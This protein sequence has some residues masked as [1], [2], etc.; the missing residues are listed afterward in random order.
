MRV[1]RKEGTNNPDLWVQV[2]TYLVNNA[3]S[4]DAHQ[5]SKVGDGD[6]SSPGE[7]PAAVSRGGDD[8]D[9]TSEDGEG[10]GEGAWDDIREVLALIE[11]EKVLPPLRV[12]GAMPRL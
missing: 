4:E 7:V 3:S 1:C 11:R 12:S 6:G 2:L 5:S 8:G 9:L 10:G